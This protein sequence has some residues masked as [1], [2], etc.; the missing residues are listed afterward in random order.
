MHT[1]TLDLLLQFLECSRASAILVGD[2]DNRYFSRVS[3][4]SRLVKKNDIFFALKGARADGHHFLEQAA[5]NGAALA[6]VDYHYKGFNF[7]LSLIKVADPLESLQKLSKAL[8]DQRKVRIV[9][10]TGSVGKTTT[11]D[12]ITTLLKTK[13]RVSSSPGNHNS[14]IGLPLAIINHTQGDEEILVLEMGMSQAGDLAK[15]VQIAPPNIAVVT[16]VALTHAGNFSSMKEIA[17]AKAEIFSHPKTSLGILLRDLDDFESMVQIGACPK[18]T[19]SMKIDADFTL[20][21]SG[22]FLHINFLG[23]H[24]ATYPR[25]P[26]PGRHNLQNFLAAV[27]VARNLNVE[28]AEIHFAISSIVL[29]ERRLQQV[30]REG[31]LFIND[32]YNASAVSVK[33]AFNSL[34]KPPAGG[35][36][37]AVIGQMLDLGQ[38]SE[39]C[40]REIAEEALNCIDSMICLGDGCK[41]I[42]EVWSS[43]KRP[44]TWFSSLEEVI[45]ELKHQMKPGDVVL[46]KGSSAN[47][48]WRILDALSK[49]SHT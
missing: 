8:L 11:K 39:L 49:E 7:G 30:E 42:T 21:E 12:F 40:H 24:A 36:T 28:W 27:A 23:E 18:A 31:V 29:P 48:L 16:M 46:L 10:V 13:Y 14:Q 3:V 47:G 38:F 41:P 9:G 32:S 4:D 19:F 43:A 15:L 17:R 22:D 25:L 1:F 33:A 5:S 6:V 34:P 2:D 35:K 37:I 44:I 45:A 26:V 20:K